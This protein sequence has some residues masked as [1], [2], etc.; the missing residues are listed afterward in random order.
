MNRPVALASSRH[1]KES[2]ARSPRAAALRLCRALAWGVALLTATSAWASDPL[3]TPGG[4]AAGKAMAADGAGSNID[5]TAE[6]LG[7]GASRTRTWG[8][9]PIVVPGRTRIREEQLVGEYAQPRWS[10][11]RLFGQTRVYVRPAGQVN[12]EFWATPKF[13]LDN[14]GSPRLRHQHEIEFGLGHRLQLD[15]YV[16]SEQ[17]GF[18]GDVHL[19]KNKFELRYAFA[20]WGKIWGNPTL[21]VEYGQN[22]K[23]PPTI[24]GKLLLGGEVA[25]LWHWG[26][27]LVLERQMGASHEHE[28]ALTGGLSHVLIDAKFALGAE[29]KIELVDD[30]GGRFD[31]ASRELLLGPSMRWFPV[32]QVHVDLAAFFGIEQERG[33]DGKFGSTALFEPTLVLGYEF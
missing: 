12:Y 8:L 9:A 14:I 31:F 26:A 15:L 21:Y 17:F 11:R 16:E 20:D 24:E 18:S 25:P 19:R 13:A 28:Y 6:E 10:T 27:N 7:N 1:P 5:P 23:G 3:P 33:D 2:P 32:P 30:D 29:M 4:R 22:A